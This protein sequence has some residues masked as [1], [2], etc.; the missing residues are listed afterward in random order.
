MLI[1]YPAFAKHLAGYGM[2]LHRIV[3]IVRC[4]SAGGFDWQR[5]CRDLS[6]CGVRA[7][8]WATLR[9][10]ELLVREESLDVLGDMVADLRPGRLRR[11]WLDH[12]LSNNLSERTANTHW[13]RLL[14][15]SPFLHDTARDSLRALV[16]R[17][18]A[19]KETARDLEAFSELLGQ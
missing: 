7:A 13:L 19:R 18:R 11:S 16:G 15:F 3:D 12:W 9:W 2:G 14:A 5:V 6:D 10:V 8:A 17:Y 1:V 4:L